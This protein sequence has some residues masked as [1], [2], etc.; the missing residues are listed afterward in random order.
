MNNLPTGTEERLAYFKEL[1]DPGPRNRCKNLRAYVY[2]IF[3]K[4]LEINQYKAL[5]DMLDPK[6]RRIYFSTARQAGKTECIA[7]FQALAAMFAEYV[8][9]HYDGKGHCYVFAPKQEQA[10]ISF[11]RF[12]NLIHFNQAEVFPD[13]DFL[14]DKSDRITFRNGF[15]VRA[16]TASRN[17]EIEGLTT[18]IIILDES[19]HIS[20]FKVRESIFPMGGGIE[21]GAKIIQC[22]VPGILGSHFHK[23]FKN[24][25]HPTENPHGYVHHIYEWEDCPRLSKDYLMTLKAEDDES[26]GR[27]YELSWS[28]SNFGYFIDIDEYEACEE[29]YDP[30]KKREEGVENGWE[31]HWGLD[32]A[33]LRDSTVLTEITVNPETNIYYVVRLI[34]M[35]GVDYIQQVAYFAGIYNPVEI[36]HTMADQTSVGEPIVELMNDKSI[37]T[38]GVVFSSKSKDELYKNFRSLI[39]K[40]KIRWPKKS[41]KYKLQ[42]E[43]S[44]FKQQLLELEIE[45]RLT[46]Y[47]MVHHNLE[48]NLARDDYPDSAALSCWSVDHYI[49]PNVGFLGD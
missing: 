44:R 46:G 15:E 47:M 14:V 20:P 6:I 18:H 22:G 31:F 45:F 2:K 37:R 10:Q 43:F 12:S 4:K 27:N 28:R 5:R 3:G 35:K 32:F 42:P 21:G 33:K 8:I 34:E 7:I 38:T 30:R 25:Y 39:Q 19:Q 40:K 49:P 24:K 41:E 1:I 17:S 16:I 11:E 29:E 36:V 23:A 9:P 26:F 13:E 48:D